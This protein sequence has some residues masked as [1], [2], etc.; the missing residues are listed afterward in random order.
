MGIPVGGEFRV[1]LTDVRRIV[2]DTNYKLHFYSLPIFAIGGA[3][4]NITSTD[5][6]WQVGRIENALDAFFAREDFR[7]YYKLPDGMGILHTVL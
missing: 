2:Q 5:N 1:P 3:F 4:H 7:N 6:A